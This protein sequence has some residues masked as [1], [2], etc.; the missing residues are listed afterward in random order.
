MSEIVDF[1]CPKC[2]NRPRSRRAAKRRQASL[3][4]AKRR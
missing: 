1:V 2:T 4:V 3:S